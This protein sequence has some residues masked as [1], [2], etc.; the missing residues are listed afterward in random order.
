VTE[1][2]LDGR[3]LATNVHLYEFYGPQRC[4]PA[5]Y[6]LIAPFITTS[7]RAISPSIFIVIERVNLDAAH[8]Y[9]VFFFGGM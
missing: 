8:S 2:E 4:I 7:M 9:Q 6:T 1:V 3:L 5:C